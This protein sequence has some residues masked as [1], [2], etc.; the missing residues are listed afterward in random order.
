[1]FRV[2]DSGKGLPKESLEKIFQR[3]VQ[4]DSSDGK[5][6]LGL[7]LVIAKEIVNRH[8]GEILVES[9]GLGKGAEFSVLIPVQSA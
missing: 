5:K 7:G 4:L 9:E 3:Y 6:G 8:N 1:M 2:K